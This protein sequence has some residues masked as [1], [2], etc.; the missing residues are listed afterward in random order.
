MGVRSLNSHQPPGDHNTG[1]QSL[2]WFKSL[3]KIGQKFSFLPCPSVS[4]RMETSDLALEN[5]PAYTKQ[6]GG[7]SIGNYFSTPIGSFFT[8]SL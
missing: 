4:W 6:K 8:D 3:G 1:P 2:F 5:F 7:M